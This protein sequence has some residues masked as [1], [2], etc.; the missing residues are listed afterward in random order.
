MMLRRF[1]ILFLTIFAILIILFLFFGFTSDEPAET[2]FR[3]LSFSCAKFDYCSD[4]GIQSKII[5]SEIKSVTNLFQSLDLEKIA[6]PSDCSDEDWIFRI[7][8]DWNGIC[9]NCNEVLVLVYSSYVKIGD[10]YYTVNGN[11]PHLLD[12][13]HSLFDYLLQ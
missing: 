1:G 12:S 13:I 5:T 7:T 6:L 10:E 11:F 8:F 3:H 2:D 9:T 4:S